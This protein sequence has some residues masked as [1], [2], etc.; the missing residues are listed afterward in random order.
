M[1][2]LDAIGQIMTHH[3][4]FKFLTNPVYFKKRSLFYCG[5]ANLFFM[6]EGIT[7]KFEHFMEPFTNIYIRLLQTTK[8][9]LRSDAGR[10]C[11]DNML[12]SFL[13]KKKSDLD[14]SLQLL[15]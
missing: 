10:V 15:H 4:T 3:H 9:E 6:D 2:K 1:L 13:N 14:F 8:E 12:S 11:Y 5:L 7:A